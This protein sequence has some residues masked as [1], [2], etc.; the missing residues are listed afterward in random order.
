LPEKLFG[1]KIAI[2]AAKPKELETIQAM[3][4]AGIF[5]RDLNSK[6]KLNDPKV[7]VALYDRKLV[8]FCKCGEKPEAEKTGFILRIDVAKNF[9]GK[10]LGHKLLG[11]AHSYFES[12][13]IKKIEGVMVAKIVPFCAKAGYKRTRDHGSVIAMKRISAKPKRRI[14]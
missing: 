4:R 6:I 2:R 13:G 5:E 7:F 14:K 9:Q 12:R 11:K 3:H 1:G 8:G 10:G